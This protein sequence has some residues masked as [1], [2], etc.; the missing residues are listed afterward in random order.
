M[1]RGCEARNAHK[2]LV[3]GQDDLR[4]AAGFG[5]RKTEVIYSSTQKSRTGGRR[6]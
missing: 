2:L 6:K 5:R 4:R 1:S 3:A